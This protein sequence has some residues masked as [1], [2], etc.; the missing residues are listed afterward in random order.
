MKHVLEKLHLK[1]LND[2]NIVIEEI[3][4]YPKANKIK[5]DHI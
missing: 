3:Y 4:K 5:M 2:R 1:R